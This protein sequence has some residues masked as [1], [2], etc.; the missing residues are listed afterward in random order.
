[1]ATVAIPVAV[2]RG[3]AKFSQRTLD[4]VLRNSFEVEG[5][6][7]LMLFSPLRTDVFVFACFVFVHDSLRVTVCWHMHNQFPPCI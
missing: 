2:E 5:P 6:C 7:W 3:D 1:M 4:Y